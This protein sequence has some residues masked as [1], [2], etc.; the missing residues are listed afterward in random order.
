MVNN[1]QK[2]L[3]ITEI[4]EKY[5][6]RG[7]VSKRG[8]VLDEYFAKKLGIDL[9]D[10]VSIKIKDV[11]VEYKIIAI[12]YATSVTKG[13]ILADYPQKLREA[14]GPYEYT[15]FWI[16]WKNGVEGK[17]SYMP[18]KRVELIRQQQEAL[19]EFM[20]NWM[21]RLLKYG[22]Y[23]CTSFYCLERYFVLV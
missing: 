11:A 2:A 15:S 20:H 22:S 12:L 17:L 19:D 7:E 14:F 18:V 21:F 16:K 9:G 5:I 3:E 6:R 1:L 10:Q 13:I 4:N 8:A 23:H